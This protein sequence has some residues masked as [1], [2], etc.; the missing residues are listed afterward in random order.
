MG[1]QAETELI[2][3]V[4]V[5]KKQFQMHM[6]KETRFLDKKYSFYHT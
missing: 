3:P 6:D 2:I 5:K 4:S 1:R